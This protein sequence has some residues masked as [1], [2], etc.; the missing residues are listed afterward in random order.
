MKNIIKL[1]VIT[2]FMLCSIAFQLN[3]QQNSDEAMLSDL[4]I[5]LMEGLVENQ[6][7]ALL[8]DSPQGRIINAVASGAIEGKKIYDYY[9]MVLPSLGW[10]VD[11][12][13]KCDEKAELCLSAIRDK[14]SLSL[15]IDVKS[16]TST[17]TYSLSPK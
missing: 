5:P 6:D 8:F 3:A 9:A 12:R 17:V 1:S 14:E 16:G 2:I 15:M 13:N 11:K 4:A 10:N 7:E